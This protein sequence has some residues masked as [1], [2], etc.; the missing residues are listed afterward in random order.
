VTTLAGTQRNV[1]LLGGPGAGKGTQAE[2]IVARF[3]LCHISTGE[4]LRAAVEQGTELGV[5]VERRM[6]T[7]E[8]VPD[9][10]VLDLVRERLAKPDTLHGILLDG[11]PRT[12]E[13][14]EGLDVLLEEAGR[15]LTHAV[16]IDV[17]DDELVRR[18][19]GRRTCPVCGKLYHA[20]YTPP[21]TDNICDVCRSPLVERSDDNEETARNRLAVYRRQIGP[22]IEYY[23]GKGLLGVVR[24]G[25]ELPGEVFTQVA[26]FLSGS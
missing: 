4:M 19:S 18:I 8:L 14:A 20:F 22:V 21:L 15:A 3:Q 26:A 25:S 9:T 7:G 17:P 16:L 10:V 2:R 1:V 23:R 5:A 13:Q 11:F 24:G 12:I 6:E